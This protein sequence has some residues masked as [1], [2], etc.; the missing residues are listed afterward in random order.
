MRRILLIGC[1]FLG[2]AAAD[3]FSRETGTGVVAL[4]LSRKSAGEAARNGRAVLWGD[5]SRREEVEQLA[6]RVRNI[7]CWIHCA[8]S[9]GRGEEGYRE[10]Y[11][12]GCKNLLACF[13]EVPGIFCSSTS[14]Y[15]QMDGSEVD[16]TSPAE[17]GAGTG[18]ILLETEREV[19]A[20][21]GAVA[22]L[23]G[24]YGPGRS[25]IVR[26]VMEG[27]ACIEGDGKKWINQIHRDDAA[28]AL[29]VLARLLAGGGAISKTSAEDFV[30]NVVDDHPLVQGELLPKVAEFLGRPAPESGEPDFGKK[31][32]WSNK[33]VRNLRLRE[34]GWR[35]AYPD[36]FSALPSLISG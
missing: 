29:L 2:K 7:D 36:F 35:P 18:K 6:D 25:A 26:K 16:E 3:L 10:V 28:S 30:F 17:P 4:T 21:G 9:G 13:P 27:R 23:A 5:V 34:L 1:G 24:L 33:K 15:A 8:S 11:L 31:R 14:V 12:D 22:R 32:G 19:L 20:H